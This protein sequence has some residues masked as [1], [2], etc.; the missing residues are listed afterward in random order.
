MISKYYNLT[1]AQKQAATQS[2]TKSDFR[3]DLPKI[4]LLTLVIGGKF[5]LLNPPFLGKEVADLIPNAKSMEFE[6]RGTP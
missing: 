3:K 4:K 6:K 1:L 2:I 5:D